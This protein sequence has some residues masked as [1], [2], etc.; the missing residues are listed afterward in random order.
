MVILI[1][2][3][4]GALAA[5]LQVSSTDTA[6]AFGS[7]GAHAL[8]MT[9]GKIFTYFMVMLGPMKLVG[10][11]LKIA[12]G[13]DKATSR[14]LATRGFLIA[15]VA[16]FA[17]AFVGR[18]I[19]GKWGISLGALLLATGLVLLLIALQAV[20]SQFAPAEP[21]PAAE[22]SAPAD[23]SVAHLA[24][25]PLAFPNIIPPYGSAALILLVTANS[26]DRAV[27][28]ILGIFLVVMVLNLLVMWFARPIVKYGS[29]ILTLL[30]AVLGVLQVA[31]AVQ[32]LL[33]AG[34]MLRVV[35]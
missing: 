8:T 29:G 12:A 15:C 30:G 18:N 34:R 27:F 31:L 16:G 26:D 23:V 20:Q 14:K 13:M 35:P 25:S 33:V 24:F 5:F 32:M 10:P 19:L 2:S 7:P 9:T 17:A 11:Y 28:R 3:A 4:F 22:A 1:G 6:G 21:H